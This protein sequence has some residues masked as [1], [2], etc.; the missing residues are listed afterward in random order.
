V[1]ED[2]F[3]S[4]TDASLDE[5][6]GRVD[7]DP[8]IATDVIPPRSTL[9]KKKQPF[10]STGA[11]FD[12]RSGPIDYD[13][14]IATVNED[15]FFSSTDASLD[16]RSGR[17]DDDPPIATDVIPPRSTLP[18]KKQPFSSTGASFDERSGPIDYDP[19]I[20]TVNQDP[21]IYSTDASLDERSG[22]LD[23]YPSIAT[24]ARVFP[25]RSVLAVG[26]PF[27]SSSGAS[28]DE[29]SGPIDYD[30]SIATMNDSPFISSHGTSFGERSGRVDDDPSIATHAKVFPPRS[31]L[32]NGGAFIPSTGPSFNKRSGPTDYDLSIATVTDDPFISSTETS[33]D[34]RSGRV[35]NNPSIATDLDPCLRKSI[36]VSDSFYPEPFRESTSKS[37]IHAEIDLSLSDDSFSLFEE[38]DLVIDEG[39]SPSMLS[40]SSSFFPIPFFFETL[41]TSFFALK[42]KEQLKL[43][44]LPPVSRKQYI[45]RVVRVNQPILGWQR[46][47]AFS[48]NNTPHYQDFDQ[49]KYDDI[50]IRVHPLRSPNEDVP[51]G[52]VSIASLTEEH[53]DLLDSLPTDDFVKICFS[54]A[55][56]KPQQTSR[57]HYYFDR[58]YSGGQC[59]TRQNDPNFIVTPDLLKNSKTIL[60]LQLFTTLSRIVGNI[61][62]YPSER[63]DQF[64]RKIN[65]SNFIETIRV[66]VTLPKVSE[67]LCACHFDDKNDPRFPA[68]TVFSKV[69]FHEGQCIR[70]S[71]ILYSRKAIGDYLQT[72]QA[73]EQSIKYVL[74]NVNS[75]KNCYIDKSIFQSSFETVQNV[76]DIRLIKP[77]ANPGPHASTVVDIICKFSVR[78]NCDLIEIISLL[79]A[80][81]STPGA[82]FYFHKALSAIIKQGAQKRGSLVGFEVAQNAA[83]L[84]LQNGKES[85]VRPYRYSMNFSPKAGKR[86]SFLKGVQRTYALCLWTWN[87]FPTRPTSLRKMMSVNSLLSSLL[88]EPVDKVDHKGAT[89]TIARMSILGLLPLWLLD[90]ASITTNN[91]CFSFCRK[92]FDL[93]NTQSFAT[94]WFKTAHHNYYTKYGPIT[95]RNFRHAMCKSAQGKQDILFSRDC[96]SLNGVIYSGE[97]GTLR[98]CNQYGEWTASAG[99]F[100]SFRC[101]GDIKTMK[102]IGALY[103]FTSDLKK[104]TIRQKL[105]QI[106]TSDVGVFEE[107]S[108]D[109][110]LNFKITI[111]FRH[112]Y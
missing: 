16:E 33:L 91:P 7:D 13:P 17:V 70:L 89:N 58:G 63:L 59:P 57:Q 86:S 20:A 94:S 66:A 8:S 90:E 39:I 102:E 26:N 31:V 50:G 68:V 25:P 44:S 19:S 3:F 96:V 103:G 61:W 75:F 77:H 51:G 112:L 2:P 27:T 79:Q 54:Q 11:S 105:N 72:K 71:I 100:E 45:I 5:R 14:S 74:D 67:S 106:N 43:L 30:P 32:A 53:C 4:S 55:N 82:P 109:R 22:R 95:R 65:K 1:N 60:S 12:E 107:T 108:K 87:Q 101:N 98:A 69:V 62:N 18:K 92:K 84:W 35:D 41:E 38:E 9:P 36:A 6:S 49:A 24:H 46:T 48:L 88:S 80:S 47:N 52:N 73:N 64:A 42:K 93:P 81:N 34:E 56:K 111:E 29:R 85:N 15:P 10:S 97:Y 23:G 40:P 83:S 28:F 99:I 110:N 21:F 76:Q 104:S 37:E 78:F